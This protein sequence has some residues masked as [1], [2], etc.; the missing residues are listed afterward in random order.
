[1]LF[2]LVDLTSQCELGSVCPSPRVSG[3]V[4]SLRTIVRSSVVEPTHF[5]S[6]HYDF[7]MVLTR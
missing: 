4:C 1:M 5:P 6:S 7:A 2:L 3:Q